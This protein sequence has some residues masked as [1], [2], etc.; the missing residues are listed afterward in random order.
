MKEIKYGDITLE[1]AL[2]LEGYICDGDKKVIK[3][4]K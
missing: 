3:E 1:E 4:E 2:K